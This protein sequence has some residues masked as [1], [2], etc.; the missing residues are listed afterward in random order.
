MKVL[1][2]EIVKMGS[3]NVI[4]ALVAQLDRAIPS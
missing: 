1:K 2:D 4:Y 3:Y